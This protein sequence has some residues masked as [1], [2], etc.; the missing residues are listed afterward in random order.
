MN[1]IASNHSILNQPLILQQMNQAKNQKF[2][3]KLTKQFKK[4]KLVDDLTLF[5]FI[6][7][8]GESKA[9]SK[10]GVGTDRIKRVQS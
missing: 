7:D 5:Q 3:N 2:I 10:Y 4:P 1:K 6:K 9:R 8:H